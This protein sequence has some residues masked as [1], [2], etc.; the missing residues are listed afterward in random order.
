[1]NVK[2][3]SGGIADTVIKPGMKLTKM[4]PVKNGA[5][6]TMQGMIEIN[7]EI[8]SDYIDTCV[9]IAETEDALRRL[10]RRQKDM[11]KDS[12]RGSMHEFPYAPKTFVVEGVDYSETRQQ[13][14]HIEENLLEERKARAEHLK[15]LVE[16]WMNTIPSR[17]QRIIQ[18]HYFE[19]L[20]WEQTAT[21]LGRKASGESVRKEL[22]NYLKK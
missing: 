5:T 4:I 22:K 1:M 13:T 18:Y 10:K 9:L 15:L 8:L 7:K 17:M 20:T 3:V 12:V 11:T 2:P 21:K 16:E 6:N 14:I 19:G